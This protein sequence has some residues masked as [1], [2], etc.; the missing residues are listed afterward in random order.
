VAVLD[1]LDRPWSEAQPV[2]ANLI[3]LLNQHFAP[4]DATHHAAGLYHG[5]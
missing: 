4:F 1:R 3:E 2:N 5:C